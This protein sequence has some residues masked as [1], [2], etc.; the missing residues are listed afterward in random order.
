MFQN[1][2]NSLTSISI[3]KPIVVLVFMFALVAVCSIYIK[4][5]NIDASPD[6]L[7]LESDPD[8]RYYREVHR[9]YGSDEFIIVGFKPIKEILDKSTIDFIGNISKKFEN[10][11]GVSSVTSLSNVPLLQQIKK[12]NKTSETSFYNLLSSY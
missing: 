2:I 8:L 9:R 5:L 7:M 6:S 1:I 11:E 12:D 10:I 3:R 4:D